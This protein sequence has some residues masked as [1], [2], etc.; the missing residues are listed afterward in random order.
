MPPNS[1]FIN[2][3]NIN[4]EEVLIFIGEVEEED[5]ENFNASIESIPPL[6]YYIGCVNCEHPITFADEIVDVINSVKHPHIPIAYVLPA[7]QN[8][9]VL[10]Y[11]NIEQFMPIHWQ[12]HLRCVNC[13]ISLS[14]TSLNIFNTIIDEYC[15]DDRCVI[16]DAASVAFYQKTL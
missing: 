15:N 16:L 1:S 13:S 6:E 10:T 2:K 12:T 14:I 4:E 3:V 9:L 8:S 11:T 5:D 7:F